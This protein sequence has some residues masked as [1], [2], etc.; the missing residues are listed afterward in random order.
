MGL[1]QL[2]LFATENYNRTFGQVEWGLAG[3]DLMP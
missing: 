1:R 2:D 3:Y